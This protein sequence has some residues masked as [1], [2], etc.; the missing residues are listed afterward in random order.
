MRRTFFEEEQRTDQSWIRYLLLFLS[1]GSAVVFA[2]LLYWVVFK[3]ETFGNT[4]DANKGFLFTSAGVMVSCSIPYLIITFSRLSVKI[5]DEGIVYRYPPHFNKEKIIPVEEIKEFKIRKYNAFRE[6]GGYG[7]R[8]RLGGEIKG[9]TM[10]GN[11]GME[12]L[13]QN[14]DRLLIGTQRPDFM[15]SAMHKMKEYC[16]RKLTGEI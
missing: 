6:F 3:G 14:G 10:K 12:I 11:K 4:D 13:L 1:F 8:K 5:T 7:A 9:M 2:F 16:E 15:D